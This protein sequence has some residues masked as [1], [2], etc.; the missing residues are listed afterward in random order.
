M[1]WSNGDWCRDVRV[2]VVS[3]ESE[4]FVL[5]VEHAGDGGVQRHLRK[6]SR[7][8]AELTINLLHVIVV[9][10]D[11]T[12]RVDKF[13]GQHSAVLRHHHCQQRVARDVERDAQEG[14][15]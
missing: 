6:C 14:V 8:A 7:L 13:A 2:R 4:V 15:G 9:Q 11:V 3:G 12:K 5:E 10:V 1:V